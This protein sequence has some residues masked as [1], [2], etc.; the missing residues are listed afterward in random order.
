MTSVWRS[1]AGILNHADA[2]VAVRVDCRHACINL[3]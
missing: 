3:Q 2:N 1:E